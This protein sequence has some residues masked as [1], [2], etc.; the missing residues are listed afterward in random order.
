M[1]RLGLIVLVFVSAC[2]NP[3]ND[4]EARCPRCLGSLKASCEEIVMNRGMFNGPSECQ[5]AMESGLYDSC[6]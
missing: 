4:L 3:C 5:R 1:L 2:G 6:R